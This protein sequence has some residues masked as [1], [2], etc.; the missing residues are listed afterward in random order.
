MIRVRYENGPDGTKVS[1]RAIATNQG[2]V[3]V[4]FNPSNMVVHIYAASNPDQTL[5]TFI[6]KG[7]V[8]MK[9]DIKAR[10]IT[11][12]AVFEDEERNRNKAETE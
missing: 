5:E 2:D 4:R 7:P 1:T 6:S 3:M 10:L 11:M 9:K 12:G 8:Q